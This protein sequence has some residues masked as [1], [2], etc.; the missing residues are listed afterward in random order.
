M[1]AIAVHAPRGE[2]THLH[3]KDKFSAE[4]AA[5]RD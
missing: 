5:S 1:S 4:L 2:V 3:C